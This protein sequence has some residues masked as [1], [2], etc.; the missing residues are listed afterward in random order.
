MILILFTSTLLTQ[1]PRGNV[2]GS[3]SSI[4]GHVKDIV[5]EGSFASG[6]NIGPYVNSSDEED[7]IGPHVYS[8]DEINEILIQVYQ[9][10]DLQTWE[11][12]SIDATQTDTYFDMDS[13]ISGR[14]L[15]YPSI[16]VDIKSEI[17]SDP[18]PAAAS[19]YHLLQPGQSS[20]TL[21]VQ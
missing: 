1:A 9:G 14:D 7:M 13:F 20:R 15:T 8:S 21:G 4:P 18:T 10:L 17:S 19:S 11:M 3:L 16:W 6:D 2:P 5:A 12:L